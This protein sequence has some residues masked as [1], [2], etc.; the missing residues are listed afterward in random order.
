MFFI[1]TCM[2]MMSFDTSRRKNDDPR[3]FS[4]VLSATGKDMTA[5][6]RQG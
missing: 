1:D 3:F 6:D 2:L 5:K 4:V